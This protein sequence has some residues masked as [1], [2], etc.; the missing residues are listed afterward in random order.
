MEEEGERL[1]SRLLQNGCVVL[2]HNPFLM[3]EHS[4]E[5]VSA[6]WRFTEAYV[7]KEG[8]IDEFFD[9]VAATLDFPDYFGRNLNALN[10]CMGDIS[11][12]ETGRLAIGLERFDVIAHRDPV[13]AHAV[14]DIFARR[15]RKFLLEG[16]RLLFLV[17][18]SD[19]DIFFPVVGSFPVLWNYLEWLDS[20][21]KLFRSQS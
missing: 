15:E 11:F 2:Y 18:S 21:R 1:E 17:Q 9:Q 10:D 4:S 7:A 8:T 13:F 19:A 14:L 5:L 3:E 20:K 12:P 6:G 16:K